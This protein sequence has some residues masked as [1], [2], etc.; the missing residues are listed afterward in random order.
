MIICREDPTGTWIVI[1]NLPDH[2]NEKSLKMELLKHIH[3]LREEEMKKIA[4]VR[5]FLRSLSRAIFRKHLFNAQAIHGETYKPKG[6][7]FLK[8]SNPESAK[9]LLEWSGKIRIESNVLTILSGKPLSSRWKHGEK[10]K[11]SLKKSLSESLKN[12]SKHMEDVRDLLER[13][14]HFVDEDSDVKSV[15]ELCESDQ[16]QL[17]EFSTLCED[18]NSF[19]KQNGFVNSS[20]DNKCEVCND[21]DDNLS[22][23]SFLSPDRRRT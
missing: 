2:V 9:K 4:I 7:A 1:R 8:M 20:M 19:M 10:Q 16:Q 21:K 11:E 14:V 5:F 23:V 12:A 17:R 3:I 22:C 15:S 13:C 18:M 6:F